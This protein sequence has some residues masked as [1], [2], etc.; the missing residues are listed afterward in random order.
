MK[1][2]NWKLKRVLSKKENGFGGG[3]LGPSEISECKEPA[4]YKEEIL[5]RDFEQRSW[6][7]EKTASQKL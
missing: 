2:K 5:P 6:L 3:Q 4:G 1:G 7:T